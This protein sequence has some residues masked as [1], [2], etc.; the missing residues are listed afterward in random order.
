MAKTVANPHSLYCLSETERVTGMTIAPIPTKD[1]SLRYR[2]WTKSGGPKLKAFQPNP[3]QASK[4][5]RVRS[6]LA[7]KEVGL[8]TDDL[9]AGLD[10]DDFSKFHLSEIVFAKLCKALSEHSGAAAVSQLLRKLIHGAKTSDAGLDW[11][12]QGIRHVIQTPSNFTLQQFHAGVG[13]LIRLVEPLTATLSKSN[14]EKLRAILRTVGRKAQ[15]LQYLIENKVE[16]TLSFCEV[17]S[18]RHLYEVLVRELRIDAANALAT[19]DLISLEDLVLP[20]LQT[21][22]SSDMAVLSLLRDSIFPRLSINDDIVSRIK[23]WAVQFAEKSDDIE[24]SVEVLEVSTRNCQST[25]GAWSE[26]T[27]A[28][29]DHSCGAE[30]HARSYS[31]LFWELLSFCR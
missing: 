29:S 15:A 24:Q 20:I 12:I 6:L 8:I 28:N 3:T 22:P 16:T 23:Q 25:L 9:V 31:F 5:R 7:K 14:E 26:L 30:S 10:G 13:L 2:I 11:L 17:R 18:I 19:K 1:C 27:G 4:L 21:R